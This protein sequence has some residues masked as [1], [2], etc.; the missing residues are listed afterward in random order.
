M[1]TYKNK[2]Y[3]VTELAKELGVHRQTLVSRA[4]RYGWALA[5]EYTLMSPDEQKL[6]KK[7]TRQDEAIARTIEAN[8]A[9]ANKYDYKGQEMTIKQLAQ[10]LKVNHNT[11]RGRINRYGYDEAVRITELSGAE[12][13]RHRTNEYNGKMYT[14][15]ELCELFSV[16]RGTFTSWKNRYGYDRAIELGEMTEKERRQAGNENKKAALG[17]IKTRGMANPDIPANDPDYELKNRIESYRKAGWSDD[18]ILVK[19]GMI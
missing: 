12:I 16:S 19:T 11:L 3:T 9:R 18:D 13:E 5:I 17:K 6:V 8:E 4:E 10:V 2:T 1:I 14:L 7:Y 15:T